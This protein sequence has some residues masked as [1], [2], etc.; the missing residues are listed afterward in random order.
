M[1]KWGTIPLLET[2]PQMAI[3]QQKKK[4]WQA[5]RW[6]AE[7]GLD[8]YGQ[9]AAREADVEDLIKRRNRAI[10]KLEA[11]ARPER[12]GPSERPAAAA[13]SGG[14]P[15]AASTNVELE[16]LVCQGCSGRFERARVRGRKPMFCP[17]CR[18]APKA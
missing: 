9:H 17:A 18:A 11:A 6:W 5:C 14:V 13:L 3:R 10:A 12:Q 1:A 15:Q 2:Y 8:L 7:R 4:D 16:V